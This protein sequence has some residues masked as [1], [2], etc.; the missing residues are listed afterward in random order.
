MVMFGAASAGAARRIEKSAV[1]RITA[2]RARGV[3]MGTAIRIAI[4]ARAQLLKLA[5]A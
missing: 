5:P 3:S 2:A 1:R 4:G